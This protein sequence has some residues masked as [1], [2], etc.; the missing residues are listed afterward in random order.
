M[1]E[2]IVVRACIRARCTYIIARSRRRRRRR[3]RR[4]RHPELTSPT[5]R[6]AIAARSCHTCHAF[7]RR[8]LRGDQLHTRD[9]PARLLTFSS[10]DNNE[11]VHRSG[12][13]PR[14]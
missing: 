1:T 4:R 12:L 3:L 14:R 8:G 5:Q 2:H 7:L 11:L 9:V 13:I 6:D 10:L